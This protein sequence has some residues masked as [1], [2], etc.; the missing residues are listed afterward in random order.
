MAAT[1]GKGELVVISTPSSELPAVAVGNASDCFWHSCSAA[2]GCLAALRAKA[3]CPKGGGEVASSVNTKS[4]C[5]GQE[6][7]RKGKE[8]KGKERKGKERKGKEETMPFGVNLMKSQVFYRA[9]KG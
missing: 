4:L 3:L 6:K 8:R 1:A 2:K 5:E 7:K 9:A